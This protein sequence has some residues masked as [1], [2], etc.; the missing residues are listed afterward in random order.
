MENPPY[1]FAKFKKVPKQW[2]HPVKSGV[3]A[4]GVVDLSNPQHSQKKLT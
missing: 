1:V 3:E 4:G 2:G